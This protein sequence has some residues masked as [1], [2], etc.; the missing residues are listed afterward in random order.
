[1]I[2]ISEPAAMRAEAES[3]RAQGKRIGFVP[4]MGY[5]HEGH[6]ALVRASMASCHATVASI[7]VNPTQ[8]GPSEDFDRYPRDI[9]R[10]RR[11][12]ESE[13]V[14]ILFAPTRDELYPPGFSTEVRVNGI[15]ENLCGG[16]RPNFLPGVTLIV[17]KLFHIVKPHAAFFGQKDYQQCATIQRMV[18]DLDFG[19]EVRME[20]TVREPDG[21]AMSSRNKYLTS[22]ERRN[23][24]GLVRA[25]ARANRAYL[26]GERSG[27][28][29]RT[30]LT[31][32]LCEVP[33]LRIDYTEVVEGETLQTAETFQS[34][35][36]A[37]VAAFLGETRLIDN[38]IL[39]E[40]L[41]YEV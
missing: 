6:L 4:T 23:A 27:T 38:H 2:E 29:L 31:D 1:M 20:P 14:D 10:D 16:R 8:F 26:A 24:T 3:L 36:V 40:P 32:A 18:R 12:L 19:I 35:A 9:D 11:L 13:G 22:E 28:K 41:P 25:L 37:L 15:T 34:P 33:G 17:S 5:L 39:G 21:L 30:I 7:F